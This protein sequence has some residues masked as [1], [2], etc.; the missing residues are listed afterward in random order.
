MVEWETR[1]MDIKLDYNEL[2][3]LDGALSG[4]HGLLYLNLSHNHLTRLSPD[5]LIGL[6]DLRWIDLSF[7]K[8]ATLDETSKTFLPSL[9]RLIVSN[10]FLTELQHD[11]YGL[12][13]LC[14]AD[15]SYN[16]IRSVSRDLVAHT[17]CNVHGSPAAL[18][19]LLEGKHLI[20]H[21]FQT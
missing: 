14:W 4:L 2:T 8:L 20:P 1:V 10:N 9:E 6:D 3:S 5:D 17:R 11:F 16:N 21:N 12:P 19:L 15:V 7:N 18:R 13:V